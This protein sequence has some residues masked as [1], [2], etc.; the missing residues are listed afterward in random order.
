MMFLIGLV[1]GIVIGAASWLVLAA[2]LQARRDN[3]DRRLA[4]AHDPSPT[5]TRAEWC[6]RRI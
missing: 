1:V 2:Y 4:R 6:E 5:G 3:L